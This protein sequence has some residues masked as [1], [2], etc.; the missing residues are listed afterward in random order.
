MS[1]DNVKNT[2]LSNTKSTPLA[3]S[4]Q[5]CCRNRYLSSDQITKISIEIFKSKG[6]G[7][8]YADLLEKGLAN[9]AQQSQS[10]LKYHLKKGTLFTLGDKRPQ[11]YYPSV[12][13]SDIMENLQKNTLLDP[14][15]VPSH[16]KPLFKGSSPLD[17]CLE[18]IIIQSLEGYVL[19]LLP[20]APLF[21][22]NMHFKKGH[23]GML[24]R[25][26]ASILQ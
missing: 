23:S 12:I 14:I 25:T 5:L 7:I 20:E 17:N 21:I 8:V 4:A 6:R 22:H 3:L 16:N 11:Q 26:K 24:F 18:T 15:G 13:R 10:T 19:P 2:P 1:D 9:H